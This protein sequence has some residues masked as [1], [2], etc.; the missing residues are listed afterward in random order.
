MLGNLTSKDFK[1]EI[2]DSYNELASNVLGAASNPDNKKSQDKAL[3]WGAAEWCKEHL[4]D[5]ASDVYGKN[6]DRQ[7]FAVCM[8]S[9]RT[10]AEAQGVPLYQLVLNPELFNRLVRP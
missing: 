2:K 3:Q 5:N 9:L 1:N 4:G 6:L 10:Q 7:A 8:Q